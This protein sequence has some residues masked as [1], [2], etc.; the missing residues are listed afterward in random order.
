MKILLYIRFVGT[1]Y[2]GYQVQENAPTVQKCICEAA[3]QLFGYPC[4]ITGCSRTDSGVHAQM[5]CATVTKKGSNKLETTVPTDKIPRAMNCFLP[6]DIAVFE[7]REVEDDFHPRYDVKYKE[8]VY[9][10]RV[11]FERNP[12]LADRCWQI[13][14]RIDEN[15]LANMKRAA[16]EFVGTYDFS[17]FMASGSKVSSTV[18]TVKYA[19]VAFDG[20]FITFTVAADGF[21]YNMVRIMTGTLLQVALGSI[22]YKDIPDIIKSCDRSRAGLTAPACGLYLNKVIY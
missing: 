7:A 9:K 12:F 15:G 19:D 18:R 16:A 3:E 22:S 5:F 4:N 13:A 6:Q 17:S 20:E 10:M 1:A 11:G 2:A 14:K 8:Y 21:L